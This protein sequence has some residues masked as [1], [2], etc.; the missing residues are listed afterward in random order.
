MRYSMQLG[1]AILQGE[2]L[3]LK[4]PDYTGVS[5]RSL[6]DQIACMVDE[7]DFDILG[8]GNKRQWSNWPPLRTKDHLSK[9]LEELKIDEWGLDYDNFKPPPASKHLETLNGIE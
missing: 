7:R 6:R 9:C 5:V 2:R 3:G 8:P 1:C 4:N